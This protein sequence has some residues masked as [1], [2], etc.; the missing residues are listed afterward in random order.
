MDATLKSDA[1][2]YKNKKTILWNLFVTGAARYATK[3]RDTILRKRSDWQSYGQYYCFER[4]WEVPI[5]KSEQRMHPYVG[6]RI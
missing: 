6:F 4:I 2:Y 3:K 1:H 5:L